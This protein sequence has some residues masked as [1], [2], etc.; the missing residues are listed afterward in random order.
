[1]GLR[2]HPAGTIAM[3]YGPGFVPT[4]LYY[5][6]SSAILFSFVTNH[7]LG[8]GFST[9]IPQQAGILAGLLAG[10]MGGYFNRTL[11]VELPI[12]GK[13]AFL[14]NLNDVMTKMGYQQQEDVDG[15][16]VYEKSALAK[17]LSGK[18]FVKL[19]DRKAT[20]ASRAVHIWGIKK[21]LP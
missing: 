13:K 10:L 6:V 21:R 1:M 15:V 9:G 2:K 8:A 7:V 14:N 18:V 12:Q 4:F 20:L 5:F 19:E 11:T 3:N 17:W 16:M